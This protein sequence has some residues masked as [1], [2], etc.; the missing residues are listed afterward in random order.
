M[1]K[2][3]EVAGKKTKRKLGERKKIYLS[4]KAMKTIEVYK[5]LQ[6]VYASKDPLAV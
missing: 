3:R 6:N 4:L 2:K 1:W 5:Y